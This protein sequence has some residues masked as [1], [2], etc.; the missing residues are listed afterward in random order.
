MKIGHC[1]TKSIII[2]I[3]MVNLFLILLCSYTFTA[4]PRSALQSPFW[5][6]EPSGNLGL[7]SELPGHSGYDHIWMLL[8]PQASSSVMCCLPP[9][10]E[11]DITLFSPTWKKIQVSFHV[12]D[13]IWMNCCKIWFS[14]LVGTN[15]VIGGQLDY[16]IL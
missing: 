9:L 5:V 11:G 1:N 7:L 2:I 15:G 8:A 4:L 14:S 13:D 10:N 12:A 3:I 16:M 6:A